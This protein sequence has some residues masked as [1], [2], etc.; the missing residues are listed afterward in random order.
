MSESVHIISL[1][2]SRWMEYKN[3]R[4]EAL[5]EDPQAFGTSVSDAEQR[6][7]FYW[8]DRIEDARKEQTDSMLFAEH[9]GTII[10]MLGAYFHKTPETQHSAHIWGVYVNS[11]FRGKGIGKRLMQAMIDK[12]TSLPDIQ[13]VRLLVNKE[14]LPAVSLYKHLGFTIVGTEEFALGDGKLHQEY[15]MEKVL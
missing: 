13:T 12:L 3:I 10:G 2:K 1:P 8:I 14:Q 4:L 11:K 7:D 9:E 6:P 5:R 15:N